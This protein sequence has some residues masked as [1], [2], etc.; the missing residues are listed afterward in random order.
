MVLPA[1]SLMS[2]TSNSGRSILSRP[3]ALSVC[4]VGGAAAGAFAS[5]DSA[6]IRPVTS[7]RFPT[8]ALS[9]SSAISSS[10]YIEAAFALP[11][12]PAVPGVLGAEAGLTSARM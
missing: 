6:S 11:E 9:F 1:T 5:P 4:D 3:I 12:V 2:V 8:T 7:T 10:L